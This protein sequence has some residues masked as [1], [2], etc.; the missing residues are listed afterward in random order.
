MNAIR[1]RSVSTR[2]V[3]AAGAVGQTPDGGAVGVHDMDLKAATGPLREDDLGAVRRPVRRRLPGERITRTVTL[4]RGLKGMKPLHA[5]IYVFHKRITYRVA[6]REER[7]RRVRV[8][9]R[10]RNR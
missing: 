9:Y 4:F 2:G 7:T 3:I 10:I 5:G 6:T 1:C 8:V